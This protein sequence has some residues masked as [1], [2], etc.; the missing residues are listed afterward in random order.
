MDVEAR[1]STIDGAGTGLFAVNAI[2][3]GSTIIE[4]T[5][6]TLSLAQA[7]SLR[8]RMYLKAVTLNSHI[9]GKDGS[10]AKYVN[11]H[12]NK[13][14]HNVSFVTRNNHVFIVAKR[15]IEVG[16]ELFVD[17]GR[18]HWLFC[19]LG[20]FL[21]LKIEDGWLKTTRTMSHH[22]VVCCLESPAMMDIDKLSQAVQ[23]GAAANC[24]LKPSPFVSNT[25]MVCTTTE[26]SLNEFIVLRNEDRIKAYIS[27]VEGLGGFA[28]TP[29]RKG[30]FL[31]YYRGVLLTDEELQDK[32][33][34]HSL[35]I[36]YMM[37]IKPNV[38]L[39]PTD[40]KGQIMPMISP[41]VCFINHSQSMS[42]CEF[43]Y[44]PDQECFAFNTLC[45]ILPGQEILADYKQLFFEF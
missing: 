2:D 19:G 38:Y 39:D 45:D 20:N 35:C 16:E 37:K 31:G 44:I 32:V 42:N 26:L 27:P 4:Y 25:I 30:D 1:E 3:A 11:D 17:Y 34:R 40:A 23:F 14:H 13:D 36:R 22:E 43:K 29:I 28:R 21:G 9:D 6:R 15:N 24:R 41:M 5:G 12:V 18:G 33:T 8:D 10:M 7:K